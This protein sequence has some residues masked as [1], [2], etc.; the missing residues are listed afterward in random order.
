MNFTHIFSG[1]NYN[2]F[3]FCSPL[4]QHKKNNNNNLTF[5]IE[6]RISSHQVIARSSQIG[7]KAPRRTHTHTHTHT[8]HGKTGF[9]PPVTTLSPTPLLYHIWAETRRVLT[10]QRKYRPRG[11]RRNTPTLPRATFSFLWGSFLTG[12]AK[13]SCWKAVKD[14]RW[15][16]FFRA[17][18]SLM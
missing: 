2:I 12:G 7:W 16:V 3:S 11:K 9:S 18:L 10:Q 5:I 8:Y 14:A 4:C 13:N 1:A 15:L 6:G 17:N